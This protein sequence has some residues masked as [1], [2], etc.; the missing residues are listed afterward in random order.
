M[1]ENLR[2][3]DIVKSQEGVRRLDPEM[4]TTRRQLEADCM[5]RIEA[6][7][8]RRKTRSLPMPARSSTPLAGE[9]ATVPQPS[10]QLCS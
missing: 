4:T 1:A 3:G 2:A 5:E 10:V 9:E 8:P 7:D 6:Q